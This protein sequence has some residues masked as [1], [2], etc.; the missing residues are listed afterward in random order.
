MTLSVFR[1]FLFFFFL[2]LRLSVL[3]PW[4]FSVGVRANERRVWCDMREDVRHGGS[5]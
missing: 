4:K 3:L 2:R 1:C 5:H